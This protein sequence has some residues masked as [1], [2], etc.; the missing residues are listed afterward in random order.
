MGNL[1]LAEL[2]RVRHRWYGMA[3]MAGL[4]LAGSILFGAS[5][6]LPPQNGDASLLFQVLTQMS[7]VGM[8]FALGCAAEAGSGINRS[9]VL[10]NEAVFGISRQR[11][12]LSRLC[13]AVLAGVALVLLML[14]AVLATSLV[15]QPDPSGL[16]HQLTC[17]LPVLAASLPMWMASAGLY[18]CLA[19]ITRSD[20]LAVVFCLL[21]DMVGWPVLGVAAM[22]SLQPGWTATLVRLLYLI[23]PMT[24]F[25]NGSITAFEVGGGVSVTMNP[26]VQSSGQPML[27]Y[28][29]ALGLG[30]LAATSLAGAWGLKRRELR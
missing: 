24:P 4:I 10:K 15:I 2:Y 20:A 17:Y 3:A 16:L 22:S 27:S 23:H 5:V 6:W 29:W 18:L 25:W 9:G 8:F 21:F 7:S 11:M 26:F 28:C 19:A 12:Y 1:I 14:A 13:V 30:W